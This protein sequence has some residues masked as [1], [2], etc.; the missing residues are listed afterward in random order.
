[1]AVWSP[2]GVMFGILVLVGL[3]ML[4]ERG[5]SVAL[6]GGLYTGAAVLFDS[7]QSMSPWERLLAA[8]AHFVVGML[9]FHF[10]ERFQNSRGLWW[11]TLFLF[12]LLSVFAP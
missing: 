10:L 6:C 8:L 9:L 3:V 7:F 5:A 11:F 1:M 4:S 2:L 12:L